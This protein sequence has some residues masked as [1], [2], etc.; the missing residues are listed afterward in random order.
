MGRPMKSILRVFGITFA[1]AATLI[2]A[3]TAG[4]SV[5]GP[6]AAQAQAEQPLTLDQLLNAV[7]QG[8]VRENRENRQRE[9]RFRRERSEQN[10]L[11]QEAEAELDAE[12]V[13]AEEL[14]AQSQ[15]N[16]EQIAVLQNELTDA[17]GEA[18]ELFGIVRQVAADTQAQL[19]TSLVSAQ[20]PNR[21]DQLDVL[22]QGRVLPTIEQLELLWAVLFEEMIEQG[23]T[24]SFDSEYAQPDG[25]FVSGSVVRV[26]PFTAMRQDTGDFLAYNDETDSLNLLAR[27]PGARFTNAAGR[28][29]DAD[30][31]VLSDAAIDPSQGQI[32]SLLVRTPSLYER[33]D[34]GREIGYVIIG[35]GI[36]GII[37]AVIRFI[38]LLITGL[39]VRAQMRAIDSPSTGN[40]LGRM[41]KVYDDQISSG[42][43]EE[44]LELKLDEQFLKEK[45]RLEWGLSIIKVLAAVAPLLGLL[46]TVTGMIVV[47]QQITLFGT[48][49][50]KLMAGGISQ[51]L[52]TTV[53]GLVA[54]IPLLLLHALTA[55]RAKEIEQVLEEQ[56][57]G[58]VAARAEGRKRAEG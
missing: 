20:H 47:F 54:A 42:V 8:R 35:L 32:L 27:Q 57:A 24:V 46:G 14:E 48:G 13:T 44:T 4:V 5:V 21:G 36:V 11:L 26:G 30:A 17:L 43:D 7:R 15:S 2:L 51:A 38:S 50:P 45:P 25:N 1:A 34:Q 23:K 18:G 37:L 31:G 28:L 41:L 55:G 29:V 3:E 40:P 49:D 58:L 56:S 16:E 22:T 12:R 9:E 33:V 53:L 6:R 19:Q 39:R 52:I 10:R